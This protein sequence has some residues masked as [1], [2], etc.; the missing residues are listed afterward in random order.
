MIFTSL[1]SWLQ[2]S[3]YRESSNNQMTPAPEKEELE[4]SDWGRHWE[5]GYVLEKEIEV[6]SPLS[7]VGQP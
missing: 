3:I 5:I 6:P 2:K 4:R 1:E 7:E